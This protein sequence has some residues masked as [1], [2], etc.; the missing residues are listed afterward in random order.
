MV[1]PVL[2]TVVRRLATCSILKSTYEPFLVVPVLY[3]GLLSFV[4]GHAKAKIFILCS[5][6]PSRRT[7]RPAAG[8]RRRTTLWRAATSATGRTRSTRS[9]GRWCRRQFLALYFENKQYK[10]HLQCLPT[11]ILRRNFRGK[12]AT[13]TLTFSLGLAVETKKLS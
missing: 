1:A 11:D 2:A 3:G 12:L 6:F 9:S 4:N 13:E 10:V 7:P 5:H 8:A